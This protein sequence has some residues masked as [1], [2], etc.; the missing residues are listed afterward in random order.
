MSDNDD[1][2]KLGRGPW[3]SGIRG[4]ELIRIGAVAIALLVVI[5]LGRP[6]ADSVARFVDGYSIDAAPPP[7]P[8]LE[9]ERLT[10]E[11]IRKRF[12]GGDQLPTGDAAP[13]P[14]APP[15]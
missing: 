15:E 10:E 11:E 14:S 1:P 6:C 12:P 4:V 9:F 5:M 2:P 13:S 8:T 3:W 7:R